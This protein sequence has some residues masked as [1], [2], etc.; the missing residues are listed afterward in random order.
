LKNLTASPPALFPVC[1]ACHDEDQADLIFTM[2]YQP[3][4]DIKSKTI[5][6]YEA[7]VRG[8]NNETADSILSQ[9]NDQNR[10]RF[11]QGCR[12][13][14]IELAARLG[15][16]ATGADLSINFIPGAVYHPEA[17]LRA[18]FNAA[19][20]SQF[21][22]DRLVFEVTEGE[23][24]S[25]PAHLVA[26]VEAYRRHSFRTAI[27]DFGAGY[28]GLNLLAKFQPDIIKIDMELTRSI[29]T[30]PITQTIVAAILQVCRALDISVIAEGIETEA[31]AKT[32]LDLGIHLLQG[33]LF[34]RP[35]FETLPIPTF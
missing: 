28:A 12:T 26:I 16:P 17:C 27:D 24:I 25:N 33:Y 6:A 9:V 15:L 30:R 5:F 21:P 18:T 8:P 34:A 10:Y 11:D 20:R 7:L 3:I 2:A 35:G 22:L 4:V 19:D 1:G 23:R 32:V 14:A 31:E 13:R 29:D